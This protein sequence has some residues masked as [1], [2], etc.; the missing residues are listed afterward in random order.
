MVVTVTV[1]G[2]DPNNDQE[3]DLAWGHFALPAQQSGPRSFLCPGAG[4]GCREHAPRP[5]TLNDQRHYCT[6]SRCSG[7]GV[8]D[9]KHLLYP[10]AEGTA[11]NR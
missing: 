8:P 11:C 3:S 5:Q 9:F 4:I 2:N 7:A 1:R 6:Y 10:P